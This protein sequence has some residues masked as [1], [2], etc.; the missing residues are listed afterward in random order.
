M[1]I[2]IKKGT[3]PKHRPYL[4]VGLEEKQF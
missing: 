1:F 2:D 4:H 3:K